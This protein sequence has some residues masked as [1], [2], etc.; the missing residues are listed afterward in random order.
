MNFRFT[1]TLIAA[2]LALGCSTAVHAQG[3]ALPIVTD[4]SKDGQRELQIIFPGQGKTLETFK[5]S[6]LLKKQSYDKDNSLLHENVYDESGKPASEFRLESDKSKLWRLFVGGLLSKEKQVFSDGKVVEKNY[7]P[8]GKSLWLVKEDDSGK[9]SFSYYTNDGRKLLRKF[10]PGEMTVDVF[11]KSGATY[12]QRWELDGKFYRLREVRILDGLKRRVVYLKKDGVS[13]EKVEYQISGIAGWSVLKTEAGDK[14]SEPVTPQMLG[15]L[16]R[17]DDSS[18]PELA[19]PV[20]EP[21]PQPTP[22]EPSKDPVKPATGEPNKDPVKPATGEPSKDP[23]K[24]A[25]EEPSKDQP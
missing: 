1:H 5:G 24:P 25:T 19:P 16:D 17:A 11:D 3:T 23:V 10:A 15:E 20:P 21:A 9:L 13:I 22:V 18:A 6:Q 2:A 8:D 7:R 4:Q 12:G 14:L